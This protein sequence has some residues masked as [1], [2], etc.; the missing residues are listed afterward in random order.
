MIT[1]RNNGRSVLFSL[2]ALAALALGVAA[3][4]GSAAPYDA[5]ADTVFDIIQRSDATSFVCLEDAGRGVRQMWDKRA[6]TE[7]D[8]NAYLFV[9][10]FSDGQP[11]EIVVNPEY[12]SPQAARAEAERYTKALGQLPALLRSGITRFGIHAGDKS[13][14]AGAGKIFVYQEKSALRERQNHL[15]ESLFHEAVHASLDQQYRLAPEWV[16]A[17]KKDGAFLT[18][19]GARYPDRED[20]AETALFA[21]GLLYYPGRIPPADD[22]DMRGTVPARIAVLAEIL[23]K[24][25]EADSHPSPPANCR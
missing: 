18:D 10:H 11:I 20:L 15:E 17:Q 23:G 24:T 3:T 4:S 21:Y 22:Q 14:H 5:T 8:H 12:A 16:A 13:F 19:Y 25:P 1:N 9:A 6:D 2:A 7:F